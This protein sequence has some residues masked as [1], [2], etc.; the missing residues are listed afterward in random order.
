MSEH[1]QRLE[2]L[3]DIVDVLE[4]LYPDEEISAMM[5]EEMPPEEHADG[6]RE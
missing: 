5:V 6:Q 1:K 4:D 2:D 3:K